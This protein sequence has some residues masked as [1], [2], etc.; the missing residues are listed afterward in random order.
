MTKTVDYIKS[1]VKVRGTN[2]VISGNVGSNT[3]LNGFDV[4]ATSSAADQGEIKIHAS[5]PA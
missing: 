2:A 1:W 3:P 5:C 4:K